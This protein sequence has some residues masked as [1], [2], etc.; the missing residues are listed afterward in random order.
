MQL[1]ELNELFRQNNYLNNTSKTD[2]ALIS[3]WG[4]GKEH[5]MVLMIELN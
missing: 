1:I 2:V 5:L 4:G 3:G